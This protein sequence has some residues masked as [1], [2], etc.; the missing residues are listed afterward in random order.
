MQGASLPGDFVGVMAHKIA[1]IE[2]PPEW[3]L[4][5]LGKPIKAQ[6]PKGFGLLLINA[7]Q[8][9]RRILLKQAQGWIK[10]VV[11]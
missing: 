4:A 8:W 3:A 6:P 1:Y 9:V 2:F 11:Q 5:R 7:V 10:Q